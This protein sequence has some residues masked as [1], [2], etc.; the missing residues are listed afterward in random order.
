MKLEAKWSAGKENNSLTFN[1]VD[2]GEGKNG[3]DI[4]YKTRA[5]T[6]VLDLLIDGQVI[7]LLHL[8][9]QLHI[10]MLKLQNRKYRL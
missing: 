8:Q 6:G 7:A 5:G 4:V 2:F 10:T 3:I 9:V 1:A